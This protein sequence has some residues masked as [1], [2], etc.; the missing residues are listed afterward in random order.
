[1]DSFINVIVTFVLLTIVYKYFE[2]RSYGV[3]LQKS[4]V[5]NK[6]YLVR[7]LPDKQEAVTL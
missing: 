6:D 2:N 4:D 3:V 5:D 7:N 1:M